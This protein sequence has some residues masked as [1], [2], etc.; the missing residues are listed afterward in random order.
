MIG[1]RARRIDAAREALGQGDL[2][3]TH[4]LAAS[5]LHDNAQDA[6]GHFLL[7]VTLAGAGQ[8]AP[9]IASL[10]RAV[11]LDPQ[12]EYRAQLAKFYAMVR[13]EG[14]A[15]FVLEQAEAALPA[16]ALSRDTMGCVYARLGN[17]NAALGHF[18][19]AVRLQPYN[20]EYRYNL[21]VTLNFLGRVDEAE[22]ALE[23]L[24]AMAGDHARAHHLLASLRK[25]S[26]QTNHVARLGQAYARA[27]EGRDRLL[28]G[29]ALAKELEDIGEPERALD[30][31]CEANGEHRRALDY[32]F[33]RDAENFD[34][35]EAS[36][37]DLKAAPP[38]RDDGDAPIFIIGMPRTGTTLVDRILSS[39][40]GVESAG[41]L[42]AMP[43]AVK[44]AAG[45]RSR[46]VLD[47]GTIALAARAYMPAIR[48]DYLDRAQHHR[49]DPAKRFID[50]FPGNFQ[51]VG[52]IARALPNARIICLRRHPMDTVLSN[53]RNLFAVSSR[54]YDYS[55]DLLDIA[56][57]YAR[58]DRLMRFWAEQLP[59]RVLEVQ[60][61]DLIADQ[62]GQTRRLLGHARL[63]W[64]DDCLSFHTNAA[65]VS[66]PSAAQVRRPIY[67]DSVARWKRHA[68][69]LAPVSHFFEQHGIPA[70]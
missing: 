21:A 30:I 8:I 15:A 24:I 50:K 34:A 41:E 5:L 65:P 49:R 45:T 17:H 47:P 19:E 12:G 4:R 25:Q 20:S 3:A 31:L 32:D 14:D 66:T 62:A 43:L 55:Y 18:R 58:F 51:Y 61:E 64:S 11:A 38:A 28:L 52:F 39:H 37:A 26:A 40:P 42:Q 59:G 13:R 70:A 33:A 9:G 22:A 53:F 27:R 36:W 67:S 23:A 69:V 57:Y 2:Q 1:L 35:I 56:A 54:Y 63:D 16:D 6:E 60:Y 48:R 44:R 7:G 10:E 29:Y 46:N 68:D